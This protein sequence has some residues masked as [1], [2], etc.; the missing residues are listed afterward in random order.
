MNEIIEVQIDKRGRTTLPPE[1]REHLKL[2]IGDG[3]WFKKTANG[4]FIM[5]KI[6]I[7]KKIIE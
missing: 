1:I 4:K 6:E 2:K 3:L 7:S 5:G